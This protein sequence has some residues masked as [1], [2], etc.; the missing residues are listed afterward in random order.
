MQTFDFFADNSP[1]LHH[2]LLTSERTE[3]EI[4]F[5]LVRLN[6]GKEGRILDVGCAFGRH[7]IE[8]ARR[9]YAAVGID[10][11]PTMIAAAEERAATAGVGAEFICVGGETFANERPFDAAICLFT[12]LGQV[13]VYG[14][15]LDLVGNVFSLL[16]DGGDFVVEAPQRDATVRMLKAADRFGGGDA[17]TDVKRNF[18]ADSCVITERFHIVSPQDDRE[19]ILRY[20]LFSADELAQIMQDAG[21]EV[22][23]R[24]ADYRGAA[25]DDDSPTMILIGRKP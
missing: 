21:F 16:K 7:S 18:D 12:T 3:S 6:L 24:F 19:Y 15:N 8:L 5:L 22:V 1:F 2:P 14:D 9:G 25:L 17:Y 20:R 13:G 4:D 23:A 10:P 11:S